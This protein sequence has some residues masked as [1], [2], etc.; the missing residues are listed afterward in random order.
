MGLLNLVE[1]QHAVRRLAYGVGQQSAVLVAHVSGGRA[2]ELGH[3]VLLGVLAHVEAHQFDAHLLCQHA[4]H[5]GLA[6]AGRP[7]EEQ[8]S[9]RF[10]VVG[11]SGLGHLYRLHHLAHGLV[12]AVD[13]CQQSFAE[14]LEGGVVVLSHGQCVHLARLGQRVGDV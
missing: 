8:G 5:L 2:N 11:Q 10:L 3:G 1:Q 7:D 4:C 13:A 14:R 6:H 12:L 9:Q